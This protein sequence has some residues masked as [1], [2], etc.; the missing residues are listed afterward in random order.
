M[1]R[2][3]PISLAPAGKRMATLTNVGSDGLEGL[4]LDAREP[5][6]AAIIDFAL[7][8]VKGREL[9]GN[10]G[11]SQKATIAPTAANKGAIR[12]ETG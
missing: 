12:R 5:A 6:N 7:P 11:S 9:L 4:A 1:K 8:G 10:T 3:W 2:R